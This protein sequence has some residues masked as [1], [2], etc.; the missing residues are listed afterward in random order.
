MQ[1]HYLP[2]GGARPRPVAS[3]GLAAATPPRFFCCVRCR[4][5][6]FVCSR[7]DR[8]QIY[9]ARGCAGAA[10]RIKQREAGRR[11]QRSFRG[12][13]NHAERMA[14]YRARQKKVTH[15]GSPD[16]PVGD[17]LSSDSAAVAEDGDLSDAPLGLVAGGKPAIRRCHWCACHCPDR[18]RREFLRRRW[19]HS[20]VETD[21]TGRKDDHSP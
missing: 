19:V 16:P 12:R 15:Q 9:C 6:A 17:V 20:T 18:V 11:Y 21:R 2:P 7:C 4:G 10:R 14:R 5:H 13:R 3:A 1:G 8:G